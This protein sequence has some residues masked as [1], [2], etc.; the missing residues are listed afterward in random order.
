MSENAGMSG[1]E[2][3][4]NTF[5]DKI[6]EIHPNLDREE[7]HDAVSGYVHEYVQEAGEEG[8]SEEES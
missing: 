1:T 5:V 7:F 4:I 6:E 3:A 2:L 8:E